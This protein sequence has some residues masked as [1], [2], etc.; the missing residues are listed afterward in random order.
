MSHARSAESVTCRGVFLHPRNA[1]TKGPHLTDNTSP[2]PRAHERR[3][4]RAPESPQAL[5]VLVSRLH[6]GGYDTNLPI[7]AKREEILRALVS[8]QV[9]VIAGETGS[10]KT[11][12]LPMVCLE[13]GRG[14]RG[15]AC[16][17]PRRIAA[18]SI[19]RYVASR[20]TCPIG[21]EVGYR[22]RFDRKTSRNTRVTFMTDGMLLTDLQ[23]DRDL[24]RYDTIIIDEAHERSLNIDFLLGHLRA[25]L[26]TRP[27]LKLIISSATIDIDLFSRS[28]DNAPVVEVSGRLYPVDIVHQP[29]ELDEDGIPEHY[30][31]A[32]VRT[33]E[34]LLALGDYGDVL[35]FMPTQQDITETIEQLEQRSLPPGTRVLPLYGRLP[36]SYQNRIFGPHHGRTVVVATNIAETSLT[37]PGIRFVVD[38]GLA[39]T[40]RYVPHLRT[41]RMPVEPVS[42]ASADQRAGRCGRVQDGTCVRLYSEDDYDSRD[43]YSTPEIRRTNLAGVILQ[44][45]FL[46]LGTVDQFPFLEPPDGR[47]ITDGYQLLSDLGALDRDRGLTTLGRRMARLPLD[48]H[49][50]RMILHAGEE[51]A[52]R[53][54]KIIAAGLSVVDPRERPPEKQAQADTAQKRFLDPLSDF[55]TYLKL[56][57]TFQG[58]WK[59]LRTQNRMRRFCRDHFLSF[60]RMREWHDVHAQLDDICRG[61]RDLRDNQS[62]ADYDR[63][64]RSLLAGLIHNVALHVDRGDYRATRD[65]GVRIFPGS[66]LFKG[67][68]AWIMCHEIV[69]TSKVYARTCAVIQPEWVEQL[70]PQLCR[71]SY[72]APR[73]DDE[74]GTVLATEQVSFFGLPIVK[75]RTVAYGKVNREEAHRVFVA[76]G[77]VEG[78]LRTHHRFL[79]HNQRLRHEV[80]RLESKLRTRSLYIGDDALVGLYSER[81]P[82]V[83][84]VHE[85]NSAITSNRGDRFL[86]FELADLIVADRPPP[87]DLPD[88]FDIGDRQ[89][90]L[91]YRYAPG[92]DDDGISARVR[93]RD[94]AAIH[95]HAFEWAL[96]Q[97]WPS[98]VQS[99]LEH[100]PRQVRKRLVPLPDSAAAVAAHLRYTA[101]PFMDEVRAAVCHLYGIDIPADAFER[102][103]PD[104]HAW[105]RV[106]VTDDKGAERY[107]YRPPRSRPRPDSAVASEADM[108][109]F[110]RYRRD[111]IT[112][113][114]FGE[115][116]TRVE[117]PSPKGGMP[118]FGYPAL[119]DDTT[120]VSI[121]VYASPERAARVHE[122]GVARL[123]ELALA[124]DLAWEVRDLSFD[125]QTRM[126][127]TPH[128]QPDRLKAALEAAMRLHYTAP[129]D[130]AARTEQQFTKRLQRKREA[131]R[132]AGQRIARLAAEV[133][134]SAQALRSLI[135]KRSERS[136][137]KTRDLRS[138]LEQDLAY[139]TSSFFQAIPP[140]QEL[141]QYPR[142]LT[143]FV[144]RVEDAFGDPVKYRRRREQLATYEHRYEALCDRLGEQHARALGELRMMLEEYAISLFA[145]QTV[146]TRYPI[147]EK[148][149]DRKITEL[150]ALKPSGS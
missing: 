31:E 26:R 108:S 118:L 51:K 62:P 135:K 129:S 77:L 33:T 63:I 48:P 16:T 150:S 87:T 20:L 148:R 22:I 83:T 74:S 107:S 116:P 121:R 42:R 110:D 90:P 130:A 95:A 102:Y 134:S 139:Y 27:E 54:V 70:A 101:R 122:N 109:L 18:T 72:A 35:V 21:A 4:P 143:A 12:Q 113:W 145:Q 55:L 94:L 7:F 58:Q 2:L 117:A 91:A 5:R 99:L 73:F 89:F 106:V 133:V 123:Y 112:G 85:L 75:G 84:S 14:V 144:K 81:I 146:K 52:L 17:Q 100:L 60:N 111:G 53:E 65:R 64:H 92:S 30:I 10:G 67:G 66:S 32:A 115:L 50:A 142:Y 98:R 126:A 71:S 147:S 28:F 137:G 40:V 86:H 34:D 114:D 105:L 141:E 37:V 9:V 46:G 45:H 119:H 1:A 38:T 69:E 93:E 79:R 15:I 11:T 41:S 56:W 78:R 127:L 104:P 3:A 88:H 131:L 76:D 138:E 136:L 125:K 49:I 29:L 61:S 120:S 57:D 23:H 13:A 24:R 80:E 140:L 39:R 132:G 59:T 128:V 97:L 82:G 96:P 19:A 25:L 6:K 103:E 8:H 44:M 36:A 43:K 68:H 124:P 149:L 47:A